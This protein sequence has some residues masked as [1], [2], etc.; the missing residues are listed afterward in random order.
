MTEVMPAPQQAAARMC[1][2]CP[3]MCRSACPTL[4][5]TGNERHQPWGHARQVVEAMRDGEGFA[6]AEVV[7]GVYACATCAA[8]TVPCHV[9]GV[10]TPELVWA[11]RA[12]VHRMGATPRAGTE[13]VR[14]AL[15]GQVPGEGGRPVDP[16]PVLA[17]LRALATPGA[18]LLLL[19]GCGTLGRRPQAALAAARAL[20]ALGVAFDVPEQHRCCGMPALTFGDDPALEEMQSVLAGT[21]ADH[22]A[23]TISVQSPSCSW[24]LGVR[25]A[26]PGRAVEPLAATL[27]RALAA[28][29]EGAAGSAAGR[30]VAYHDPCYL[31]RHQRRR[32][33]PRAALAATGHSL[34]ELPGH[35]DTTQCSGQG[36]GLPLTHPDIAAGYLQL[37]AGQVAAGGVDEVVSGCASCA[38]ALEDAGVHALELAEAVA[39]ALGAEEEPPR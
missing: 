9:D 11:A 21:L 29:G 18:D 10:E 4:A 27:A 12:A 16:A 17:G 28:R 14:A 3:K 15:A 23:T 8:C 25:H 32:D 37:L 24:M 7:D 26:P 2:S 31:A 35:G 20:R 38:A 33:E 30:R 1:A 22:P 6:A 5:V 19:P 34:A 39:A 36:G 13:A